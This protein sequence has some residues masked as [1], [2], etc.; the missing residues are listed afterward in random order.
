MFVPHIT[1]VDAPPSTSASEVSGFTFEKV[2]SETGS[3]SPLTGIP[4]SPTKTLLLFEPVPPVNVS[5]WISLLREVTLPEVGPDRR[6]RPLLLDGASDLICC[7]LEGLELGSYLRGEDSPIFG[8]L[9][10]FG[11]VSRSSGVA[12]LGGELMIAFSLDG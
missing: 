8:A 2:A 7:D 3:V 10:A 11:V 12:G 1:L 4:S 9:V 5:D 6:N